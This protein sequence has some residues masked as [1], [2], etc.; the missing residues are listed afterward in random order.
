MIIDRIQKA[1]TLEKVTSSKGNQNKW[2]ADGKWYKEDGLGYEALAEVV[3][4]KLLEKTNIS[5]FVS[6]S[7]EPLVRDGRIYHGC[8]SDSFMKETDDKVV[9]VERLFQA[10]NGKGAALSVLKYTETIDRIRF[11]AE[12]VEKVTGLKKFGRYLLHVITIDTLFYNE[13]RH[14]HNLAVIE[15][16]DGTYREC[17]IFDNGAALF[18]DVKGDYPL[19]L[20]LEQCKEKI[21]A[22]PFA[23]NFD[24]QLDACELAFPQYEFQ[25]YF[26]MK[27]VEAALK[28]FCGIY[29]DKILQRVELCLRDRMRKYRYLFREQR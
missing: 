11:V 16:K 18:S 8:V 2:Y 4:S 13:D 15:K 9:S 28:P 27:D 7:Y 17:P 14:F 19:D 25:A 3:I 1:D 24:D 22:K 6:Y 10:W 23:R 20:T 26:T 12:T 29:E 21:E 5:D